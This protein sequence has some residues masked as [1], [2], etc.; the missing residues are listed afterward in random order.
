MSP[1][2]LPPWAIRLARRQRRHRESDLTA[3]GLVVPGNGEVLPL[4]D[5]YRGVLSSAADV[6]G[7]AALYGG[8]NVGNQRGVHSER[9]SSHGFPHSLRLTLPPLAV[10]FF[11]RDSAR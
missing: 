11:K 3:P 8:G 5:E 7:D 2:R 4:E 9:I 10:L 6:E 1:F